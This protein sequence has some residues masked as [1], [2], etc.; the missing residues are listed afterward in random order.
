MA[1]LDLFRKNN[2]PDYLAGP[3]G[4]SGIN[5]PLASTE[6]LQPALAWN[7][8]LQVGSPTVLSRAAALQVPAVSKVRNVLTSTIAPLPLRVLNKDGILP[9]QPSWAYRTDGAE[10]PFNRMFHIVEDLIFDGLSILA[11]ERGTAGQVLRMAHVDRGRVGQDGKGNLLIDGSP[12]DEDAVIFINAPYNGILKDGS[13]TIAGARDLELAW[14]GRSRNPIP[15][16]HIQ[17]DDTEA[18]ITPAE[19][20]ALIDGYRAA[21]RDVDGAILFTEGGYTVTALGTAEAN[22]FESGR[23]A[24]TTSIGQLANVRA[25]MLDGTLADSSSLT[26]MTSEGERSAFLVFDIPFY[27]TVIEQRLSQDDVVPA[28]QRVRFDMTGLQTV[29]PPATGAPLED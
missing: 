17:R 29:N 4:F 22:L 13:S 16:V 11:V 9:E 26:Y 7:D 21:R 14:Q 1:F 24:A 23:N 2:R 20:K 28:G 6:A 19:R 15:L 27:T 5:S 25:S 8:W 3:A 18:E 12:V 10:T